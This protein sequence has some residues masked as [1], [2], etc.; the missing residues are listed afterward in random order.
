MFSELYNSMMNEIE[1]YPKKATDYKDAVYMKDYEKE[2]SFLNRFFIY[3]KIST[4]NA[5][6]LTKILLDQ[7]PDEIAFEDAGT[8]LAREA[9]KEAEE[10]LK[11]RAKKLREKLKLQDATEALEE[12]KPVVKKTRTKKAE[13][14]L[15][16]TKEG[17][18]GVEEVKEV[19]DNIP[20]KKTTRKKKAVDFDIVD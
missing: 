4:R 11:P 9:V 3:K 17:V 12:V 7:L 18:E 1:K 8:M 19:T 15:L 5:E 16:E 6:K 20:K 2:I 10:I 13:V 14:N